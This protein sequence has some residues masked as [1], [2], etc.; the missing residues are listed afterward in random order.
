MLGVAFHVNEIIFSISMP[1]NR[2]LTRATMPSRYFRP[3][4][5]TAVSSVHVRRYDLSGEIALLFRLT[6]PAMLFFLFGIVMIP[7][8]EC[9][10]N[11]KKMPTFQI[12]RDS[13]LAIKGHINDV[14]LFSTP[15]QRRSESEDE[16][17]E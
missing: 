3:T 17:I 13:F 15:E 2:L 16:L 7:L 1:L 12:V 11:L 9:V 8:T 5:A 6:L 4:I 10:L 14:Q